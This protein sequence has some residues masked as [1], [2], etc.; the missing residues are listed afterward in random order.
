MKLCAVSKDLNSLIYASYIR[1]AQM[2]SKIYWKIYDRKSKNISYC[3]IISYYHFC[4]SAK[5]WK[6]LDQNTTSM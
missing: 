1:Y 2:K 4:N 3:A 6:P 5:F